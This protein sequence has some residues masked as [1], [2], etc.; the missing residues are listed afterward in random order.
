MVD[1]QVV[2]IKKINILRRNHIDCVLSSVS[3]RSLVA[4]S[5]LVVSLIHVDNGTTLSAILSFIQ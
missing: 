2:F 3:W 5:A 1:H 4:V